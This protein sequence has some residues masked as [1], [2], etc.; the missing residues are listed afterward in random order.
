[1]MQP[2]AGG[3][4]ARPFLTHHNALDMDRY[5]RIAPELYLKRL[6]VGGLERVYEINRNFRNEGIDSNHNPEFTMLEFYTA[7]F[8][9]A[10]VMDTTEALL[11]AAAVARVR[12]AD[13]PI[14]FRGREV[15]FKAPF[16]RVSMVDAVFRSSRRVRRLPLDVPGRHARTPRRPSCGV[17]GVPSTVR[18]SR[19]PSRRS[20]G[21]CPRPAHRPALRGLR[22]GDA[23]GSHVRD[24]PPGRDLAARQGAPRR[25]R[26]RGPFRA[27]RGGDGAGQRL[28]RAERSASSSASGSS[29][30]SASARRET[31]KR[32]RWTTTTCAP[33]AT[34]SR[35]PGGCGVGIDRL[36]MVLTGSP[37]IRD[38]ILFPADMRPRAAARRKRIGA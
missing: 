32:T 36:A 3:A 16:A 20:T 30:S 2:I 34:G 24:G 38:V 11:V 27:V 13:Q 6:V 12:A 9:C 10:D 7:Y 35:R 18:A 31:R 22:G 37:S 17:R 25:S 28:L 14:V 26:D 23:L 15:S 1:M 4:M 5:L 33:S 21:A 19:G 29:I 8:D